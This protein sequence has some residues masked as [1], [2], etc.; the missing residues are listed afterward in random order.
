VTQ[1]S[2]SIDKWTRI[3][4]ITGVLKSRIELQ[5]LYEKNYEAVKPAAKIISGTVM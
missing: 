4:L 5:N 2:S 1:T 3:R